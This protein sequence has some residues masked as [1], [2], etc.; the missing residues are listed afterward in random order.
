MAR[1]STIALD[2]QPEAV[3]AQWSAAWVQRRLVEAYLAERRM[4]HAMRR[5]LRNTW[6]ATKT[7]WEDLIGRA[8]EERQERFASWEYSDIGVSAEDVSKME[9]AQDWLR[10]ILARYPLERLCLAQWATA[11]AYGHSVSQLLLRREWS[12]TTFYRHVAAG[13]HVIALEL[14]RQ[15]EPVS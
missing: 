11:I 6:P 4:P 12:R 13:A 9:A 1:L 8:D 2:A 10:V 15:G 7:E 5:L 14:Q 3:P